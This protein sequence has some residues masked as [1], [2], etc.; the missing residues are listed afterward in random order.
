M[1]LLL[2]WCMASTLPRALSALAMHMI[3]LLAEWVWSQDAQLM[4]RNPDGP[5]VNKVG[6]GLPRF[7]LEK[8]AWLFSVATGSTSWIGEQPKRW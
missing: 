6:I 3:D 4:R 8:D 2:D 1:L 7:L 5:Q